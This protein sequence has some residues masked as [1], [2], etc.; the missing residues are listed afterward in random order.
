MA[1][2]FY[3]NDGWVKSP[4]GQALAGAQ[5]F[6]CT[7]PANV[8]ALPP[9]L[10]AT[11]YSDPEGL[12]PITQPIYTDGFGHY[13]FYA[14]PGLYTIVVGWAGLVNY[15]LPDQSIGNV[16]TSGSGSSV[17]FETNGTPDVDQSLRNLVQG[18]GITVS[19]DAFGNTT[20]T[21]LN[22]TPTPPS[23]GMQTATVTLTAAQ[24]RNLHTTAIEIVPPQA[25]MVITVLAT[26]W[27][28][29]YTGTAFG[30]SSCYLVLGYTSVPNN[31]QITLAIPEAG[32]LDQ[33]ANQVE[34]LP[35]NDTQGGVS[36]GYVNQGV[37]FGEQ[38]PYAAI[39][40][41]GTSTLTVTVYYAVTSAS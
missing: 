41:G 13:N 14:L 22:P 40:G 1:I 9:S 34:V 4:Q 25:G 2:N 24:I 32:F 17:L 29:V 35:F 26:M 38:Q 19:T 23:G 33:T 3:R 31:E 11:V 5:I 30:T 7:Q 12:F 20:F 27:N 36:S 6:V 39:T 8:T 18:A 21:N 10:L 16:G 15:V 28:Y 37:Y